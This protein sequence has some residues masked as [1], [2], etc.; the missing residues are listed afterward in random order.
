[1]IYVRIKDGR[2][3]TVERGRLRPIGRSLQGTP[4][5]TIP[6][7]PYVIVRQT[8]CPSMYIPLAA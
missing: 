6:M 3:C 2:V 5:E 4:C 8:I 1:M 7:E